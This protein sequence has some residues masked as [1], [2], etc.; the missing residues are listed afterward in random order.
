VYDPPIEVIVLDLLID[1]TPEEYD[2]LRADLADGDPMT[3]QDMPKEEAV[4]AWGDPLDDVR[5]MLD[6]LDESGGLF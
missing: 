2:E 4:W 6:A 1:I 5:A 3:L